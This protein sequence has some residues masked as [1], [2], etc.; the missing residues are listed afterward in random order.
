M[1]ECRIKT[2]NHDPDGWVSGFEGKCDLCRKPK[3]I[4]QVHPGV[5][6]GWRVGYVCNDCGE[7]DYNKV[8][9]TIQY[10]PA[11]HKND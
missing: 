10:D 6:F 9:A 2:I 4:D 1:P 3:K 5:Q 7:L 8:A 11:P